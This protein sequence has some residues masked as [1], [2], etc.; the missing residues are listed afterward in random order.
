MINNK[1][2]NLI[3]GITIVV[4]LILSLVTIFLFQKKDTKLEKHSKYQLLLTIGTVTNDGIKKSYSLTYHNDGNNGK[5]VSKEFASTIYVVDNKLKYLKDNVVYSYEL[6][7]SYE[8]LNET[9][10]KIKQDKNSKSKN[11]TAS[12]TTSLDKDIINEIFK[13][14]YIDETVDRSSDANYTIKNNKMES[15]NLVVNDTIN[16]KKISI[17]LKYIELEDSYKVDLSE[18]NEFND[19]FIRHFEYE[20]AKEN[21]LKIK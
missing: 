3:I 9:L 4:I 11:E 5:V 17:M 8:K 13:E 10:L 14:L 16:Y 19:G 21:I 12:I 7:T 2:R 18:L 15:L 20:T 1:R 6:D